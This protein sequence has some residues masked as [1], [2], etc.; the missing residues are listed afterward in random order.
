MVIAVVN[1]VEEE[2]VHCHTDVVAHLPIDAIVYLN[3]E[4][5]DVDHFLLITDVVSITE[6]A[7]THEVHHH[8]KDTV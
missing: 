2:A 1:L 4:K 7:Q 8:Q 6:L 5:E 3:T